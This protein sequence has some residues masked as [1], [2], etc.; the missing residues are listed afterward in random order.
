MVPAVSP[1]MLVLALSVCGTGVGAHVEFRTNPY[2]EPGES[3]LPLVT[4]TLYKL[5]R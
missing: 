1:E 2:V 5:S 3:Q 4:N